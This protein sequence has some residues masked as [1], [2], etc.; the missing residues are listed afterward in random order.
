MPSDNTKT[1]STIAGLMDVNNYPVDT[2]NM[3]RNDTPF[4]GDG[5][6][7][8]AESMIGNAVPE[9]R[10]DKTSSNGM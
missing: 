2:D 7:M 8:P 9:T 3:V 4:E 1:P 5:K 6:S 10:Y